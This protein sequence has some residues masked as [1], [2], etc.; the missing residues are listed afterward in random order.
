MTI[1]R[2]PLQSIGVGQNSRMLPDEAVVPYC[3]S[4][5]ERLGWLANALGEEQKEGRLSIAAAKSAQAFLRETRAT[6]LV[7]ALKHGRQL[8]DVEP[9]PLTIDPTESGMPTFKDFWTLRED[10]DHAQEQLQQIPNREELIA[11]ATDAIYAGNRPLKQQILWLQ[12][13]YMERLAATPVVADFR[14]RE[15]VC[16]DAKR[17]D[18]LYAVS[19]TGVVHSVNLF[20]CCTLHF[21]ES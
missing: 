4:L 14:Q 20:E 1:N 10:R 19:W 6:I 16:L 21:V 5:A 2:H 3:D 12:R 13:S 7:L 15:P 18:K 9:V 11:Q 8:L 17:R